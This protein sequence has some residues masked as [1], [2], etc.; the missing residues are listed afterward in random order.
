M[1]FQREQSDAREQE[2]EEF[3]FGTEIRNP[4][5]EASFTI[6]AGGEIRVVNYARI[7]KKTR[8]FVS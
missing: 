7:S 1:T 5:A 4:E 6:M 8:E 3:A 2:E